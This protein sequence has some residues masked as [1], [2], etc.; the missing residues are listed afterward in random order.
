VVGGRLLVHAGADRLFTVD[1]LTPESAAEILALWHGAPVERMALGVRSGE[2]LDQL[3]LLGALVPAVGEPGT[4]L[5]VGVVFAGHALPA[6]DAAL[7]GALRSGA[8]GLERGCAVAAPA[9]AALI[10]YVRTSATLAQAA[11][12]ADAGP[13]VPH[14]FLDLAYDH[15]VSIGPLVVPPD[16]ACLTCLAGRIGTTWG[17]PPPPARPGSCRNT[18]LAC[19]LL[20]NELRKIA[21]GGRSLANRTVAL[22]LDTYRVVEG[23]L[24]KHPWCPSCGRTAARGDPFPRGTHA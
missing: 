20:A 7:P 19:G 13:A 21:C 6:L 8:E 12:M 11:G 1:E 14:L 24:L 2:V 17:D 22:D 10:V 5:A 9:E 4:P 15:T 23:T 3:V 18:E 16:T